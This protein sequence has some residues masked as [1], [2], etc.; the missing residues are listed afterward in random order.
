MKSI[1]ICIPYFGKLPN[2]FQEFLNTCAYNET[3]DF[4]L[5]TDDHTKFVYPNNFRIE[6]TTFMDL[7][8]RIQKLFDFTI[9]LE[10][11]NKLCDFRPAYGEIFKKEFSGYD[12]WG[13][14]DIDLLFGN[15]RRFV[16][17]EL[18]DK[19]D[20]IG[21]FGHFTIYKNNNENNT[22][23]RSFYEYSDSFPY[24]EA[25]QRIEG[26]TFDEWDWPWFDERRITINDLYYMDQKKHVYYDCVIAD[27]VPF[28]DR[29][30]ETNY[31][32]HNKSFTRNKRIFYYMWDKG[33]LCAKSFSDKI[34]GERMYVHLIKRKMIVTAYSSNKSTM[35]IIPDKIIVGKQTIP[36][37]SKILLKIQNTFDISNLK[38][39]TLQLTGR[40]IGFVRSIK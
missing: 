5:F 16:S 11:P 22:K 35:I 27:I 9:S 10:V 8:E 17:D 23:Y 25:F 31:N 38:R 40:F 7:K 32:P 2:Y 26:M 37:P 13:H 21:H 1:I 36:K 6:F 3:V 18:L 29:F 20:K 39:K 4:I 14:C 24:K 33:T 30:I 12:F 34:I 15:I 19:Y 28:H